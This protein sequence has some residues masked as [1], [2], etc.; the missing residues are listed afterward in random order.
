MAYN[1]MVYQ[2][3]SDE[4]PSPG[5]TELVATPYGPLAWP[6]SSY[7]EAFRPDAALLQT[8]M[9]P[10]PASDSDTM[11]TQIFGAQQQQEYLGLKH[12]SHL[13]YERCRLHRQHLR[14]IDHRHIEAQEKLFGVIINNFPDKAKRQS[15]LESQLLQLESQRREEE[16][17]FWKDTVD[18]RDK[19]FEGATQ[20]RQ[21]KQRHSIFDAVEVPDGGPQ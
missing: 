15:N 2:R 14:D 1:H 13:F 18:L 17:A 3:S 12:L 5:L 4:T 21:A 7:F 9:S 11:A 20:Y 6:K 10:P 8:A 19:L 16:L